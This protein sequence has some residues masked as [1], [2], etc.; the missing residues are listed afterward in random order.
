MCQLIMSNSK[1]YGGVYAT[2]MY[3]FLFL[4]RLNQNQKSEA[5]SRNR[6]WFIISKLIM[7]HINIVL[8]VDSVC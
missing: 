8:S 4:N 2:S 3:R 1:L 5:N 6:K 7:R